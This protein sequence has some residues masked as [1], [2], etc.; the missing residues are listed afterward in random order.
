MTAAD[1]ERIERKLDKLLEATPIGRWLTI[2]EAMN[3]AKI[4]SRTTMLKWINKG[5]VYAHKRTG[6][7][8]VDR[9]SIDQWFESEIY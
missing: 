8:I 9:K 2:T 1:L 4:K 3:Y 5:L 6:E 7:W